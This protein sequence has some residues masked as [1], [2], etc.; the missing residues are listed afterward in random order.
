MSFFTPF[1]TCGPHLCH[2]EEEQHSTFVW[3]ML[4]WIIAQC[5]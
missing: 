4:S 5:L 1:Q 2:E 3:C